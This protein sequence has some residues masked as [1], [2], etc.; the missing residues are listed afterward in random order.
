MIQNIHLVHLEWKDNISINY[1]DF[2]SIY[3]CLAFT[4]IVL[5]IKNILILAYII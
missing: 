4:F 3:T 1:F 2:T 5:I